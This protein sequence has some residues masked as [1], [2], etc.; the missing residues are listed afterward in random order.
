[1]GILLAILLLSHHSTSDAQSPVGT[2]TPDILAELHGTDS[3]TLEATSNVNLDDLHDANGKPFPQPIE[4]RGALNNGQAVNEDPGSDHK[5]FLYHVEA[6]AGDHLSFS[7]IG[8]PKL[9]PILAL[10]DG[11]TGK[12]LKIATANSVGVMA[13]L[14]YDVDKDGEYLI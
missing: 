4:D 2:E 12:P 9:Q 5:S 7:M 8:A 13:L 10:V 3:P 6:N 11:S 1:I 14:D